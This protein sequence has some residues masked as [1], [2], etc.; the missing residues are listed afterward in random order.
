MRRRSSAKKALTAK[1]NQTKIANSKVSFEIESI[2]KELATQYLATNFENN[3]KV[4]SSSVSK[5]VDDIKDGNFYLSW[6]CLAFN[7]EG[8]LVNGQHRLSAVIEADIPCL[9]YVLRNIEHSTV[10]HFDI[11]NKRSQADRISVH[12]TP[13]HPKACAVIKA[14]FGEWDANF[15]GG[16]KFANS[17]YD[18]L[19]ASYYK[20]HSEYFEQLEADGYFKA[21]YIGNYVAA[22]FKIF[23]EMKVGKA[24][25]NEYPHGMEPYERSTYWLDLCTDGK[26]KDTMIDY[27]TDQAPFKLKEKLIARKGL[28]KTMYG[29]DAFKLHCTAAYYFMQGRCPNIRVDNMKSDPF[30]V[31]RGMSASNT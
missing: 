24:R 29:Q 10:K 26:S 8:Q 4:R 13:M 31:F 3:R 25:F 16:A 20:R 22:A 27:N 21:K 23:L 5:I 7:E 14:M 9:F 6:D 11:G 15:T 2:G 1:A 17:K 30:S 12:G 28:G 19:I 18:D